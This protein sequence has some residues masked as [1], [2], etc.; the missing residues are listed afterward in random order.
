MTEPHESML[1]PHTALV[2]RI[3]HLAFERALDEHGIPREQRPLTEPLVGELLLTY[4]FDLPEQFVMASRLALERAGIAVHEARE[5]ACANLKARLPEVKYYGREGVY[6]AVTGGELEA[7]LLL[8]DE[9][10]AD[11]R[12]RVQGGVQ[13]GAQGDLVVAVPRRDRLL[14]ADGRDPSK[15]AALRRAAREFHD[16]HDDGHALSLQLMVRHGAGWRLLDQ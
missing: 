6:L 5:I 9:V 8:V 1:P 11:A 10:W 7:C 15:L 12:E 2:P 4:A 16:E 13:G 3:K 14:I